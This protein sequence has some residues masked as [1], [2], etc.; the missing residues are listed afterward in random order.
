[1]KRDQRLALLLSEFGQWGYDVRGWSPETRAK[2]Q[3][4][5]KALEV[6]LKEHRNK[7]VLWASAADLRAW[8]FSTPTNATT[9]NHYRQA[10]VAFYA[11]LQDAEY[12]DTNIALDLP[13]IPQAQP[14]PKALT[15]EQAHAIEQAVQLFPLMVQVLVLVYLYVAVR[16]TEGRTLEWRQLDLEG[17]WIRFIAKGNKERVM[18]LHPKVVDALR[19]WRDDCPDARWVFPSDYGK[20]RGRVRSSSWVRN[21]IREVGIAAGIEH[22]HPHQLRHTCATH[23][24]ERGVDVRAVQEYLGHA[25]L[26]TTQ[27]YL[28]VRPVRLR[29][30]VE[31]I[32][33]AEPMT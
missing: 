11:F 28:R 2:Y 15:A 23:L 30:A 14:L 5:A 27:V 13:R 7:S 19:A 31:S 24:V 21:T 29:E 6:W 17:G 26:A 32:A 12:V 20:V 22:L 25:N 4:R 33:Y 16:K 8:L 9:R 3:G 10:V 18:P 1:M